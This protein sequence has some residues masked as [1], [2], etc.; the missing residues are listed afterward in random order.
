MRAT[1]KFAAEN[2][3]VVESIVAGFVTY[4]TI[5]NDKSNSTHDSL[6]ISTSESNSTHDSLETSTSES[7]SKHNYPEQ[8]KGP[9]A[10]PLRRNGV[11]VGARGGTAEERTAIRKEH[12]L[13]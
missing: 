7:N 9:V 2:P 6:K 8:R 11:V 4:L 12:G 13:E 3:E 10:H 5:R 1:L